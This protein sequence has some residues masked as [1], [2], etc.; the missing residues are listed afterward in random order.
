M[1]QMVSSFMNSFSPISF[2]QSKDLFTKAGKSAV[3]TVF[4]PLVDVMTNETYFGGPVYTENLPY[5]LQ[6]P[7][8]SLSFRSPESVKS[9][10]R[11]MNEAT[12]GSVDVRVILTSTQIRCTTSLSTSSAVLVSS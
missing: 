8:S 1:M 7:E 2:G 3:P 4:K 5:G 9:F 10:P 6:R 12:G 11:W